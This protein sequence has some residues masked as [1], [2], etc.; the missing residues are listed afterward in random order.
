MRRIIF[1]GFFP[2]T[3]NLLERLQDAFTQ[4]EVIKEK[5]IEIK[6]TDFYLNAPRRFHLSM[7]MGCDIIRLMLTHRR[8]GPLQTYASG[9]SV[10]SR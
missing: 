9:E 1:I 3:T 5:I 4:I 10:N 2:G 6:G 8:G 7:K